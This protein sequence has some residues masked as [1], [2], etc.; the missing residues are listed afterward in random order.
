MK[1][2]VK[3]YQGSVVKKYNEILLG[4]YP[5]KGLVINYAYT[6]REMLDLNDMDEI[7]ILKA[8]IIEYHQVVCNLLNLKIEAERNAKPFWV[9]DE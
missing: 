7:T 1:D 4:V 2:N 9:K 8:T 3:D 6:V 5:K